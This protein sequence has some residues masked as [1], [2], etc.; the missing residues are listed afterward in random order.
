MMIDTNTC[1]EIDYYFYTSELLLLS[2]VLV[3]IAVDFVALSPCSRDVR[4]IFPPKTNTI[5]RNSTSAR[6][7]NVI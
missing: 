5:I 4:V 7:A 1:Y 2:V 3:L 6:T